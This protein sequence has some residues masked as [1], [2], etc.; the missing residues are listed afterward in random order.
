MVWVCILFL[1]S[2][3]IDISALVVDFILLVCFLC[4]TRINLD[5][6]LQLY[7]LV[8]LHIFLLRIEPCFTPKNKKRNFLGHN[9]IK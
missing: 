1:S 8:H 5:E 2:S 9:F 4:Y 3:M 6:S 7:M